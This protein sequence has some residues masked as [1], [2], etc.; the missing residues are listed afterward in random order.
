MVLCQY[1]WPN[2]HQLFLQVMKRVKDNRGLIFES[3]FKYIRG[4]WAGNA[5][6]VYVQRVMMIY[7]AD[8]DMLEEMMWLSNTDTCQL[9]L[10]P[11]SSQR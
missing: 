9:C 7:I 1:D 5:H 4:R 6:D 10:L 11:S 8:I 3:F 2:M